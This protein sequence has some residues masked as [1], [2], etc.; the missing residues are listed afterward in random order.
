MLEDSGIKSF[1]QTGTSWRKEN[2]IKAFVGPSFRWIEESR[3]SLRI[4]AS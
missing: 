4:S 2:V 1:P 3:K